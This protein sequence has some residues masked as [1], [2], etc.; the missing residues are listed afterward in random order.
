MGALAA[1]DVDLSAGVPAAIPGEPST[2]HE[3]AAAAR[4]PDP[5][6]IACGG[7]ADPPEPCVGYPVARPSAA[8]ADGSCWSKCWRA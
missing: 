2:A 1:Y 5:A 4:R 8:S 3:L 7:G 6:D